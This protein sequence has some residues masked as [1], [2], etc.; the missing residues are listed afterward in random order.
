MPRRAYNLNW[1]MRS[2]DIEGLVHSSW[3]RRGISGET[4]RRRQ[5]F[6]DEDIWEKPVCDWTVQ[7]V[8]YW[9]QSGPLQEVAG[10][11]QAAYTHDIS[12]SPLRTGSAE[13]D[14]R[15]AAEDGDSSGGA[16]ANDRAGGA[17]AETATGTSTAEPHHGGMTGECLGSSVT[18]GDLPPR[19]E[20]HQFS[21]CAG[22]FY[23][24]CVCDVSVS[25]NTVT[26]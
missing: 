13:A 23:K 26:P 20:Q 4:R 3:T 15:S 16:S 8:C 5:S 2:R 22:S 17:A 9:F 7:D 10:L 24:Q 14:G 6:Q 18:R 12:V 11:V 19:S 21:L 1:F 25:L